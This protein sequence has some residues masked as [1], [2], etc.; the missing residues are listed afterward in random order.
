MYEKGTDVQEADTDPVLLFKKIGNSLPHSLKFTTD[1]YA[2]V[3]ELT[4]TRSQW[5]RVAIKYVK[6][7]VKTCAVT[8]I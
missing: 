4:S 7:H 5:F 3:L 6:R 1:T 2:A 8:R